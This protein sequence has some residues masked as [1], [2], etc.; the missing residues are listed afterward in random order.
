MSGIA[1][2]ENFFHG[3]EPAVEKTQRPY[4]ITTSHLSTSLNPEFFLYRGFKKLHINLTDIRKYLYRP[5]TIFTNS[6]GGSFI[7]NLKVNY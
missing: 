7:T 4:C 2:A 5:N 3:C 6:A 1:G